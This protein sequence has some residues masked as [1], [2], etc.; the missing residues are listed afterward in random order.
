M[1][2]RKGARTE[3]PDSSTKAGVILG[4]ARDGDYYFDHGDFVICAENTLFR[5]HKFILSRDSSIFMDMFVIGKSTEDGATDETSVLVSD[6]TEAFRAL[7]WV[8]YSL[9]FLYYTVL[10]MN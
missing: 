5:V 7:L 6:T 8:L 3:G 4:A 9:L 10:D 2:L 1:D